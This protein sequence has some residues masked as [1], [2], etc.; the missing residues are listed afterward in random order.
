MLTD[1]YNTNTGNIIVAQLF[2]V[3]YIITNVKQTDA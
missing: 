1:L 2:A 3:A